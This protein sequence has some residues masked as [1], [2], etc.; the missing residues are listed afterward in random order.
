ML[1]INLLPKLSRQIKIFGRT[2]STQVAS[3][4]KYVLGCGSNVVDN[5]YNVKVVPKAGEKGFFM[6]PFK[7][8]EAKLIGGVTLNHLSWAALA[9]V[10]AGLMA[11]QGNDHHGQFIRSNL[12]KMGV[13]TE[14][15]KGYLIRM[16]LFI[17]NLSLAHFV[18]PL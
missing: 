16:Q 10:P 6:S 3:K 4:K 12:K 14:F 9:G 17:I 7:A 11:F 18:C 1:S 2:S 5:I 8:L 15:I 13:T